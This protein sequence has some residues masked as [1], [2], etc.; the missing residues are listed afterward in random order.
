MT[1]VTYASSTATDVEAGSQLSGSRLPALTR[2]MREFRYVGVATTNPRSLMADT[3]TGWAAA[4]KCDV[5]MQT[6]NA[7]QGSQLQ[8]GPL[9]DFA[10]VAVTSTISNPLGPLSCS[11]PV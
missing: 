10:A 7:E 2:A 8:D 11:P 3:T 9:A 5:D 6:L 4:R 1:S